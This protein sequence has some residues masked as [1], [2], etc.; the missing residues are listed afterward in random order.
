MEASMEAMTR[1]MQDQE[2]LLHK[3]GTEKKNLERDLNEVCDEIVHRR[4]RKNGGKNVKDYNVDKLRIV[5]DLLL[6]IFRHYKF[7]LKSNLLKFTDREDGSFCSRIR[8][9]FERANLRF[10][11]LVW[12]EVCDMAVSWLVK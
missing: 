2:D 1:K 8:T 12:N 7:T 11:K 9:A 6:E 4:G 3:L 10:D 5:A